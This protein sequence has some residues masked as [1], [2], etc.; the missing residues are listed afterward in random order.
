MDE[1]SKVSFDSKSVQEILTLRYDTTQ[2]PKLQKLT[3]KQFIQ[4]NEKVSIDKIEKLISDEIISKIN[5]EKTKLSLALSGGI[6]STLVLALIR[7]QFPK[8]PIE[9]ISIK[10]ADSN[11]ESIIASKTAEHFETNHSII[12]LEN[13]LQ[14]LPKAI[15]ISEKP[16]WDLHWYYVVKKSNSFSNCL[17]SGD[18]GD[19]LFGGYSFRYSKFLTLVN[20][21]SSPVEKVK[22]YL[23]CHERDRVPDQENIFKEKLKFSWNSIYNI[24][25]PYFDNTLSLLD[26]V[27]LADYNGKL[28]YNFSPIN[29][30]L[31]KYFKID[32]LT[33]I[34]SNNMINY[35]TQISSNQKYNQKNNIGKIP[36]RTLL[37]NLD[38]EKFVSPTKLGFSINTLNLWKT[39]GQRISKSYLTEARIVQDGLINDDWIKKY[40]NSTNLNVNY[41]NKFLGLLAF[42]IWYRLFITKEM[43]SHEQLT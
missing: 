6:D 7:K 15:Y 11:D 20:Q 14:E 3:S 27:F 37:K 1:N 22:A 21:T 34:L 31:H 38:A 12:Y 42:E 30:K 16:F 9:T 33:P 13:F 35:S 29:S 2:I 17:A 24:L 40:L 36:L 10:F 43:K 41:V 32:S 23:Q 8:I 25:L 26:Q 18:G 39:F 28:L 19:E 4:Q 5:P